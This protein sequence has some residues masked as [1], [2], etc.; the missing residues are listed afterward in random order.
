MVYIIEGYIGITTHSLDWLLA[1]KI[2]ANPE[3]YKHESFKRSRP[4]VS[5]FVD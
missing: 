2:N 5:L 3:C 4:I 1:E